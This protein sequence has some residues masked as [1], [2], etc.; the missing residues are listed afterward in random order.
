MNKFEQPNDLKKTAVPPQK[1][2]VSHKVGDAI[3]RVGDKV[4]NAGAEK[5][6]NAIHRA[7]DKIE[8]SQDKKSR[9]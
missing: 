1:E 8:H 9:Q 3:E 2:T 7:G 5:I 4:S 6:G